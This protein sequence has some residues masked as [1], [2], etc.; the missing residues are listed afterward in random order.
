MT[1]NHNGK[2]SAILSAM[3]RNDCESLYRSFGGNKVLLKHAIERY[4]MFVIKE[5]D[6]LFE[7]SNSF[8]DIVINHGKNFDEF[9]E[10]LGNKAP[11]AADNNRSRAW[12][13]VIIVTVKEW[14][15]EGP[16]GRSFYTM[17]EIDAFN[18]TREERTI[19]IS[20]SNFI[21]V[22]CYQSPTAN[23][24]KPMDNNLVIFPSV[25]QW[26]FQPER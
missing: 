17:V 8:S 19:K 2:K 14:L 13:Y 9:K 23:A 11:I 22:R 21:G 26:N 16:K 18:L 4:E 15:L 25:Q 1:I 7:Q 20:N 6:V 5:I 12:V 3:L 24:D 10:N